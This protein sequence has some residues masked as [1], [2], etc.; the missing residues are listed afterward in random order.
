MRALFKRSIIGAFH[1]IS[2]RHF[3][4]Y[5]EEMEWRFNNRNNPHRFRDTLVR[6]VRTPPVRCR[7]LVEGPSDR[8]TCTTA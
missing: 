8:K 5:M 2:A 7:E 1:R 3:G 6:I 4:R